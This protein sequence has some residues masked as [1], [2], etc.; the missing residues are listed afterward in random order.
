MVNR[1][2]DFV[3]RM[4]SMQP[5]RARL[6]QTVVFSLCC[7]A[8]VPAAFADT[9]ISSGQTVLGSNLSGTGNFKGGTLELDKSSTLSN[10]FNV[11]A[12]SGNTIDIHGST[13]TLSGAFSNSGNL[14]ITDTV[15][16][17]ALT[18][19]GNSY[20]STTTTSSSNYTGTFTIN[21]G[22]TL[23]LADTK[24]S[25]GNVTKSPNISGASIADIGTF[26]ISGTSTG[27][28]I[29]TLSGSG[30]VVLGSQTL[31]LSTASGS[32]SGV[33]SGTG[34]VAI[35]SGTETFSGVNTYTGLTS[36]SGTLNLTGSGDISKSGAVSVNGV[37]DVSGTNAGATITSLS[38]SG[39]VTLG[40]QNLTITGG[41]GTFN[42]TVQGSGGV[43]LNGGTQYLIGT[44]SYT[45][46][47]TINGGTLYMGSS[48]ISTNIVD[49]AAFAFYTTGTIAMSGDISGSGTV[50]QQGGGTT[51]IST[52]QD[53][54][55]ATSISYGRIALSGAGSIANSSGVTVTG[56]LDITNVTT[57]GGAFIKSL[58]GAGSV[59][60][61]TQNLNITNGAGN[62]SGT[63][64]GT[65]GVVIAGGSEIFSGS[66][67]YSGTTAIN[68]GS[69]VL[70]PGAS[71]TASTVAVA[72]GATLDLSQNSANVVS[73]SASISSLSGSG[74]VTLGSHTLI[75]NN[76]A[77]TFSGV[78]SG[79]GGLTINGGTET[80]SGANTYT[81]MTTVA[82][83]TLALAS[84][85]S[86]SA[87]SSLNVNGTL[88]ASLASGPTLTFTS[89]AGSGTVTLGTNN[90]QLSAAGDTFS[91]VIQGT[92]G[93]MVGG[94]TEVLA[95]DNTYTGGTTISGGTLQ[96]GTSGYSG[97]ITGNV[98]DNGTLAFSRA[99]KYVFN[100][101]I[102][103]TGAVSQVGPGTT[104]LTAANTYSGGTTITYGTL[105]VGNGGTTGSIQG[106]V[107]DNSTLAFARS[108]NVSFGGVISGKGNV[109]LLSGTTTFSAA[110]T[111]TGTT[112]I[113][114]A[115]TL[116]LSGSGSIAGSSLVTVN[117]TFDVSAA[118]AP[119]VK[120]L[121]GS[122]SVTLGAA[123]LGIT[124]GQG[125]FSGVISG[126]GGLTVS[127]GTQTLSGVNTYT[128]PTAITGG[129]LSVNGSIASSSGV[130]IGSGGKLAG[131][132]TVSGLTV[133]SG[134]TVA[135]GSAGSG[136]LSVNGNV[137]FAG[138]S[139]FAVATS[140]AAT[141][142]LSASG[143]ASLAGALTLTSSDGTYALGQDLVVLTAAGGVGGSCFSAP[144]ITGNGAQFSSTVTCDAN[145]VHLKIDLA[146]LS[147]L[148]ATTAS[149]NQKNV[150]KAIDA[151]ITAG[152]T[153]PAK[154]ENLGND[155]ASQLSSDV[156]QLDGEVGASLKRVGGGL[157]STFLDTMSDHLYGSGNPLQAGRQ[158][159]LTGFGGTDIVTG[160][161]SDGS[162]S[163]RSSAVGIAGGTDWQISPSMMLGAAVS[164]AVDNF[165]LESV[166]GKGNAKAAQAGLYGYIQYSRHFYGSF[167][168][169]VQY[170]QITTHR[171]LTVSGTDVLTGK[172]NSTAFGG[173][174]ESGLQLP[175]VSPYIAVQD[176]MI[177]LPSYTEKA[178]TGSTADFALTY[179]SRNSNSAD[180]EI[181]IRQ[182]IDVDFTPRWMLT[183]DGTLHL[184]DKVAWSHQLLGGEKTAAAFASLPSSQFT[185]LG[186]TPKKDAA[187]VSLGADLEFNNGLHVLMRMDSAIT[188]TSQAYT[189]LG[190]VSYK[191]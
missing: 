170:D 110:S 22:A 103:G 144:T 18:L 191:W 76:A 1:I 78:I 6:R 184:T 39:T 186:A 107:V 124:A 117:G 30:S 181:G 177:M 4:N 51:T 93:L 92:G 150:V 160:N 89:L 70:L 140:S 23:K 175:W 185:V 10:A 40:S 136:T 171:T 83:G 158:G 120:G 152:K 65:G 167:A 128:G 74:S 73:T 27:V 97:S 15:G 53:Y 99:D 105:Q 86:L 36:V 137:S 116:A 14:T 19:T 59:Y 121:A 16:G 31:V 33:I 41:A 163:L 133:Q 182:N 146:S 77:D 50:D 88:D 147:P 139:A 173:R 81:G 87:S 129:T 130:T 102:S 134:G 101:L 52:A 34:N 135:P 156:T 179:A 162:H 60:L 164:V 145:I 155:T 100:G 119:A 111:F 61:G 67:V 47:T 190:G 95:G 55:G 21:S 37:L 187:L 166:S 20:P 69:L 72:N 24:D 28:T 45:G 42:G 115:S 63:I 80:L 143:S 85:G 32:Y 148:L 159:W 178:A 58:A 48:T 25:S 131:N 84:T 79:S 161:A 149:Q 189:G 188:Q 157:L 109:N 94:G 153:L 43:I 183:P 2:P 151:A 123:N 169:A 7:A 46:Q 8:L 71:L 126:T 66:S 98:A 64:S 127:G 114:S 17:G 13:S 104:V 49:N 56:T 180:A 141:S 174:Y 44:N 138:G 172:V 54:T 122:G 12:V 35:S 75:I 165:H 9:D 82:S 113:A 125:D 154:I 62:F 91:G 3:G 132:G 90:L 29:Y 142:K 57:A 5:L 38:G 112:T 11:T 168:A 68:S 108:D 106:N 176:R 96:I 26:D 118:S